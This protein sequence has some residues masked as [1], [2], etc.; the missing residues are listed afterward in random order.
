MENIKNQK[1]SFPKILRFGTDERIG[2]VTK[3]ITFVSLCSSKTV[4]AKQ[5]SKITKKELQNWSGVNWIKERISETDNKDDVE[6]AMKFEGKI[7]EIEQIAFSPYKLVG[8]FDI[9]TG[10]IVEMPV[11]EEE[12]VKSS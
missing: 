3:E 10:E 6:F 4:F 9:K 2:D 5:V 8:V 7:V 12:N 1:E 11:K